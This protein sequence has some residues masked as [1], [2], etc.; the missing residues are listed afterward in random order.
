MG[1]CVLLVCAAS[2]RPVCRPLVTAAFSPRPTHKHTHFG[3]IP[4]QEAVPFS[5]QA[6][7]GIEHLVW[8]R[9][10]MLRPAPEPLWAPGAST[11]LRRQHDETD[12]ETQEQA[13]AK[14]AAHSG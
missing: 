6:Y 1:V 5:R 12:S 7:T 2:F 13:T 11:M 9:M 8:P 14:L 3:R 4:G 10:R